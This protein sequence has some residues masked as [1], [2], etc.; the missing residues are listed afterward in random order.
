MSLSLICYFVLHEA[1]RNQGQIAVN[2]RL[3]KDVAKK[4]LDLIL[5]H[6]SDFG[7]TLACEKLLE[8]HGVDLCIETVRKL[9]IEAGLWKTRAQR[10]KR[11]HQPRYRRDWAQG[12]GT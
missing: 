12:R 2:N 6:Y 1:S 11:A 10:L 3:P 9:M 8:A 4:A 5:A 7:P